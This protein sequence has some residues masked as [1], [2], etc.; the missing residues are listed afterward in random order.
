MKKHKLLL[1]SVSVFV[2]MGIFITAFAINGGKS[3][4]NSIG[5]WDNPIANRIALTVEN[6]EFTLKKATESAE[7]YT[8]TLFITAQKTQGDF[9]GVINSFSLSGMAYDSI[10]FTALTDAAQ[11]KTMDSLVLTS[12]NGTPDTYKWQIDINVSIQGK[13]T[14]TPTIKLYVTSG[15]TKDTAS[16]RIVEIPLKITVE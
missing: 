15:M 2:L 16:E 1:I 13:G 8:L 7:A 3:P 12:A 9:Y 6:T 5:K 10:V 14:Y 4:E 11:N